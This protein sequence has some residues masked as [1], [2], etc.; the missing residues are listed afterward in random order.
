MNTPMTLWITIKMKYI[1]ASLGLFL[2]FFSF[3]FLSFLSVLLP[4]NTL[5]NRCFE[6]G[7]WNHL[8]RGL[9]ITNIS[10]II[11]FTNSSG[12]YF[13]HTALKISNLSESFAGN[14]NVKIILRNLNWTVSNVQTNVSHDLS[15]Y[16][17]FI[18]LCFFF[19][20]T[21]LASFAKDFL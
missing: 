21:K 2:P 8:C 15:S 14:K 3:P 20:L 12:L 11:S 7:T 10:S 6:I 19:M 18:F 4:V 5:Q 17:G 13:L 1:I 16:V 9:S